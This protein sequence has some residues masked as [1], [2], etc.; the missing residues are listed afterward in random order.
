MTVTSE[1]KVEGSSEPEGMSLTKLLRPLSDHK[2]SVRPFVP[3]IGGPRLYMLLLYAAVVI[4]SAIAFFMSQEI[5]YGNWEV[6]N[7]YAFVVSGLFLAFGILLLFNVK[8]VIPEKGKS[9]LLPFP[10]SV[11]GQVGMIMTVASFA[12]LVIVGPSAGA[13]AVVFSML[14]V[15]GFVMLVM[16]SKAIDERD[17][18]VLALFGTGLILMLLVPVHEAFDV[19]RSAPGE[20][21]FSAVNLPLFAGGMTLAVLALQFIR[22]RDGLFAAWLL[23]AMGLFLVAF[24]EQIGIIPTDSADQYDRM[25]ATIG[26]AFSFVPLVLYVWREK[27]YLGLWDRL[28]TTNSLIRKG[29]FTGAL[30]S[31]DAALERC[32]E[33]GVSKRFALPWSLKADALYALKEH[34]KAKTCYEMA[35]EIDP[36][37]GI[38]WCQLGNIHALDA[39]RALALSAYDRAIKID[40]NNAY[41][42]NNKG[43]IFVSLAWPEEAMVCF[44][45]AMLFMPENFDAHVNLAKM[46]ARLGRHDEAVMHFQ[47]ALEI[48]PN[49][50]VAQNGL[51][52]QFLMGQRIDQ[53]RGWE[54]LG[55]DTRP[56]WAILREDPANF[57]RRSKEFLS[58][59]VDQRTQ[60]TV[61]TGRERMN[62]NDAIRS[63]LDVTEKS[64]ATLEKI[65][66][67][68]GLSKDQLVLPMALLMKTDRLHFKRAGDRDIYVSKGKA[69][70]KPDTPQQRRKKTQK[71]RVEEEEPEKK[72]EKKKK[73]FSRK[74]D[75]DDDIEP[76]ASVLV[77][78]RKKS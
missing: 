52:K 28:R 29:D 18:L 35:L 66:K 73:R 31:S 43:V 77:F 9:T 36:E 68:T 71:P 21:P 33:I 53:I 10:K 14:I 11:I 70:D 26:F 49:S 41:A 12:T 23:G 55:L 15:A 2:E 45:K 19:G 25:V 30:K 74:K 39:K 17:S 63:I 65:E 44:N 7:T 64:G 34:S 27:E 59:I 13:V 60:M 69:P 72:P 6:Y 76:T 32:F 22:T 62:V 78:G 56:L 38:S 57:G 4:G 37:D 24:H 58:S 16:A 50:A 20:Y 3:W 1:E 46:C 51:D 61:G 67:D 47:R 54:Q 8:P 75:K 40:S 48:K 5:W 42:W